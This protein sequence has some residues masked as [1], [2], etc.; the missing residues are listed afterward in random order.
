MSIPDHRLALAGFAVL[1]LSACQTMPPPRAGLTAPQVAALQAQ[2]FVEGGQGWAFDMSSRLLFPTDGSEIDP[3]QAGTARRIA[4]A[5]CAVEIRSAV[6]EGHADSTGTGDYNRQL[7]ERRALAVAN[8]LVE[9]GMVR[10]LLRAEGLGDTRPIE[11]NATAGGRA[12]NRRVVIIVPS[13][14]A[15]QGPCPA[16]D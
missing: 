14:G 1:A 8:A 15:G 6:V 5:L 2:G 12:E 10:G 9:G 13:S 11:S 3:G 4:A 7:S 16:A